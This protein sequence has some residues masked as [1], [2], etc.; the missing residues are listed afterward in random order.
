LRHLPF[1]L[2]RR[3]FREHDENGV[4]A[5]FYIHPWELDPDQPRIAVPWHTRMRHYSGLRKTQPLLERLLSEFR[6]RSVA[7]CLKLPKS[8][9]T[10]SGTA[11]VVD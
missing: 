2:I 6:F 9:A 3:A 5:M 7:K 8:V 1:R 10:R 4:P 11:S